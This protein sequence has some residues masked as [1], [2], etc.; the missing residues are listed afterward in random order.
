MRW[1]AALAIV[2]GVLVASSTRPVRAQDS[3]DCMENPL[4][5]LP[6]Y[7]AITLGDFVESNSEADGRVVAGA[8]VVL[9]AMGIATDLPVDR[10]RVDLAAGGDLTV[11]Y[12]GINN[13]SVTYGG[14]VTPDGFSVPNGTVTKAAPPFNVLAL[15]DALAVRAKSWDALDSTG[16]TTLSGD[17]LKLT[18]TETSRNVFRV[19]ATQ[20]AAAKVLTVSVPAGSTV[21][22]NLPSASYTSNLQDIVGATPEL[23]IWNFSAAATVRIVGTARWQGTILAPYGELT[24][25]Y[26]HVNGSIAANRLTG[27]GEIGFTPATPCLPDPTPCPPIPPVPTPTP[28]PSVEPTVTPEP[29]PTPLPTVAPIVTPTATPATSDPGE[30]L[31]PGET[32]GEVVVAGGS[33]DVS[34]CKKVMTKGGRALEE[35]RAHPGDSVRFRIR[36][37]NLGTELAE[38][39]LVCDLVPPGLTFVRATVKVS[40][41]KGRPCVTIPA[42]SGQREAF[43][44]MRVAGN[45]QGLITNVAAVTSRN[46]GRRTNPASVRVLPARGGGGGGVTG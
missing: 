3:E 12:S 18:G 9:T 6:A 42:L 17:S 39:V 2:L 34:I 8:N 37:T 40:Y 22:I 46:G 35:V 10:T 25:P 36:V 24:L 15:F 19:S 7:S 5:P 1:W 14:T 43:V 4:G 26:M 16:T 38:N 27:T 20:L 41:R 23:T 11:N 28:T 13:G 44:T 21:L 32:P 30:P 31:D 45:V 29:T 33:S